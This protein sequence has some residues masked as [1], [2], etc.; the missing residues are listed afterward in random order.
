MHITLTVPCK[1]DQQRRERERDLF[2]GIVLLYI[3]EANDRTI[4]EE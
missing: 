1:S 4:P 3:R 2:T